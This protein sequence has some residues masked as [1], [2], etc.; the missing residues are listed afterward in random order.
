MLYVDSNIFIYPIIYYELTIPESKNCKDFLL[1]I[2]TGE[3]EA[4]TSL[5]TWDEVT[6]ITRK[7]SGIDASI[8]QGRKFLRFPNLKILTLRKTTISKAQEI[9]EKY[10]LKARDAIH[11]A[12]AL[13][14]KITTIVSYDRD[15]D[16]I[17]EL[18]RIEP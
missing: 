13:E 11:A 3:I 5:V 6:G 10:K 2:A 18:K 17:E 4:Y 7:I 12:T 15:F 1:R 8:D 14:G 9:M 16:V